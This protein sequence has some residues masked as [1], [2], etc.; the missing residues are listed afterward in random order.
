MT[1]SRVQSVTTYSSSSGGAYYYFDVVVDANG[2]VSIR[3]I[4]SPRGLIQDA[5]TSIPQSVLDDMDTAKNQ[6]V[7]T[8]TETSIASGD[9]VWTGETL[10]SVS[11][12]DGL[13]NNTQYRV[14]FT[15]DDGTVLYADSLTTDGFDAVCAVAYGSVDD[16]KTSGYVVLVA[17]QQAS[18]QSGLATIPDTGTFAVVFDAAMATTA[19]RV[20][21]TP[22]GL[23]PVYITNKTRAGFTI[24][25]GYTLPAMATVT[26]GYDVFV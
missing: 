4:R 6:V 7:Q 20:V 22:V 3:N 24:Q 21:M 13:V 9:I 2:A 10:H 19:Y 1:A 15:T 8:Q 18:T 23:F 17:T 5:L 26:V 25:V 12:D 16:P 11:L 14:V